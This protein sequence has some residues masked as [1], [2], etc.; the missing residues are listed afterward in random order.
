MGGT[1][2]GGLSATSTST[3]ADACTTLPKTLSGG[4]PHCDKNQSDSYGD[5]EWEFWATQAKGCLTTYSNPDT[6]S[7]SWAEPM[8]VLA[9][10]GPVFDATK[11]P[12]ELGT[13]AAD[14]AETHTGTGGDYSYI[15]V[16]GWTSSPN[17]EFYIIDDSYDALPFT[18]W[19]SSKLATYQVDG[20]TY[21]S[22]YSRGGEGM[23][24][25][26]IYSVRQSN[27][28]CGHVSVS[29]HFAQWAKANQPLGKLYEVRVFVEVG[30]GTG[31]IDFTMAHVELK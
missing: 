31:S 15:G 30:G 23:V 29:E 26:Q 25:T 5:Y 13:F 8:T 24:L 2:T 1:A 19:S 4:T 27:R 21:D 10:V 20:E 28:Q 6:F 9:M 22:F 3:T 12:D 16:H 14:F 18:P 11:T 7:V 17:V